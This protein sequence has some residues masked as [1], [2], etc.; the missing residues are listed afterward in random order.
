[1]VTKIGLIVSYMENEQDYRTGDHSE[2]NDA[3]NG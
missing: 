3:K 2:Y 1:V